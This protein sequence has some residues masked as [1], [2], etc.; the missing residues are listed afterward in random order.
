MRRVPELDAVRGLAGLGVV[1]FHFRPHVFR[2]G[3]T[4]VDLFFVLSGYLITAIILKHQGAPNFIWAFYAR[5]TL[6]IWPIYYVTLLTVAAV[7]TFLPVP[8]TLD[9]LPYYLT[10][11]QN[12]QFYW[13][14]HVAQ[15]NA[16]LYHLW[17]LALEEQFYII[18]PP[19]ILL[20]GRKAV[21]PLATLFL[22][23]AVVMRVE[24]MNLHLLLA[25]S[26]G[27]A[28]GGILAVLFDDRARLECH[29]V[30]FRAVMGTVF[31]LAGA[32]LIW[33]LFAF[34]GGGAA[35]ALP[36]LVILAANLC[37][38]GLVGLVAFDAGH[39]WLAPLRAR[40][41][42]YI[43]QISY[44]LYLYHNIVF[45]AA[46][47]INRRLH[48]GSPW[49]FEALKLATPFGIAALSWRYIEKPILALKDRF[50]Y[51]G[52]TPTVRAEPTAPAEPAAPAGSSES[53]PALDPDTLNV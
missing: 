18:W 13:T 23:L 10:Y 24:G 35:S 47:D 39:P 34:R 15:F 29:A 48:L 30:A 3:W 50:R 46:D 4:C 33:G 14:E 7:N 42:G 40:W 28:L 26:D 12:V 53:R 9:A 32:G 44:G 16:S 6:R 25:R 8:L 17:S 11:T 27:F 51:G 38:F 1:L 49:W 43:G 52:S 31:G 19:L 5:R 2:G 45:E 36:A 41:L 37:Y 20:L 21:V 22:V